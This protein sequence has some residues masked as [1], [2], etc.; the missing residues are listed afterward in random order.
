MDI[1]AAIGRVVDRGDLTGTEMSEVMHQIMTGAASDAQIAAFLMGLRMKGET[2]SE[3]AAAAAVMRELATRVTVTGE[4]LVDTC[5]TGGDG[6]ATFNISTT[7]AFVAAGAG[8]KV[9]KHGNRSVSSRSGSADVLELAGVRLDL[10]PDEIAHCVETAG[11]GFMF[12]PHHHGAMRFAIGPRREMG[13][14]TL[15]NLLGPLTNPAGAPNQVIGVFGR[16]WVETIPHVLNSLGSRHVLVVH[17]SDGLDELSLGG[18][19]WVGELAGGRVTTYEVRPEDFGLRPAR[20]PDICVDSVHQSL[21][22][23][24]A[25]LSGD[26]GPAR[27]IVLLNAGAALYAAG[28]ALSLELGVQAAARSIDTGQASARL[29]AL[30]EVSSGFPS[31]Q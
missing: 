9:A 5:G 14:R 6:S 31:S 12:A 23:M 3:L 4:H 19:T 16:E 26:S 29:D 17:S 25:V 21:A 18:P 1:Q 10:A 28:C 27:D 7:S 24:K 11:V 15:F 22:I 8:A 13:T 30:V 2:V 20:L